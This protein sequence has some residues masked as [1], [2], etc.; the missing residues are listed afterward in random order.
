MKTVICKYDSEDIFELLNS[1]NLEL[2]VCDPADTV[3]EEVKEPES[4]AKERIVKVM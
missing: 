4:E 2:Q 3:L 1:N